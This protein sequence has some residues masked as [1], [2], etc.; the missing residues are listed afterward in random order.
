MEG[1][2]DEH[3]GGAGDSDRDVDDGDKADLDD[4]GVATGF[5]PSWLAPACWLQSALL[6]AAT[7]LNLR[8]CLL[9]ED[10]LKLS[11]LGV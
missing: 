3:G 2:W 8:L 10:G 1:F 7:E 9:P 4:D 5:R 6:T 11:G